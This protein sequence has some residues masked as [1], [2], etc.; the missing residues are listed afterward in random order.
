MYEDTLYPYHRAKS[1]RRPGGL[2]TH[3]YVFPTGELTV[4]GTEGWHTQRAVSEDWWHQKINT[5]RS[6][7]WKLSRYAVT[8]CMYMLL[9]MIHSLNKHGFNM[10]CV[11]FFLHRGAGNV[12]AV[13]EEIRFFRETRLHLSQEALSRPFWQKGLCRGWCVW[14]DRQRT[15]KCVAV[16][17]L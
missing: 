7:L 16:C 14:L 9:W 4:A 3:V 13:C 8:T 6:T 17:S 15:G 1:Q 5:N 12:L 11:P 10:P 2:G